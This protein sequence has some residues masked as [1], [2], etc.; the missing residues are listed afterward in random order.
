MADRKTVVITGA[1]TGIGKAC[2]L[3]LVKQ[4]FRVWAGVRK[5]QD[6]RAL[7]AEADGD[8]QLLILDVTQGDSIGAAAAA[9]RQAVGDAGLQGLVNNAGIAV[10]GM[11]ELLPLEALRR[12]FEVNVFGQVAVT[13]ALL[14]LLRQGRGRVVNMGSIAGR[15]STPLIGAYSASKFALEALTDALRLELRPWKIH[16]SIIE[17]GSIATPIW[18][19]SAQAA[20]DLLRSIPREGRELYRTA[21]DAVSKAA[22]RHGAAGI[23]PEEVAKAVAHALTATK[24]KTRYL[25]GGDAKARALLKKWMPDRAMDV[26]I[27][28]ALGLP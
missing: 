10:S 23:P 17:P 22:Q 26:L 3:R 8:I 20:G 1:S 19:K 24:P 12:Q 5:L 18:E 25:V 15:I 9:L 28:R 14:P 21:I 16:V 6:G 4:G 2:A 7:A 11:L 27:A 13:Q